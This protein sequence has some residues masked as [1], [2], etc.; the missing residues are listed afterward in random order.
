MD[1]SKPESVSVIVVATDFSPGSDLAIE[2]AALLARQSDAELWL[3]HVFDDGLWATIKNIYD[4]ERWAATEPILAA[5]DRLSRLSSEVAERYAIRVHGETRTGRV[6]T[7]IVAFADA[8]SAKLLVV[9]EHGED[10]ISD[11]VLGGTTLK[12]LEQTKI[13]LLMVCRRPANEA[14][15][16]GSRGVDYSN[17]LVAVDFSEEARRAAQQAILLFPEAKFSL[18]HAYFVPFEGRMRL[19]GASN[20]DIE[21]YRTA[22][23]LR[24][25]QKM[26][27]FI[28]QLAAPSE[29]RSSEYF[30]RGSPAAAILEQ[31]ERIGADLI[32]IGKHGGS[33]VEERLLGSVTRNV[34]Y[35]AGC[36]VL[37]VP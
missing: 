19:A 34:L 4:A 35:H 18:V 33:I 7:E 6:A 20:A 12:V 32:V 15:L 27:G 30:V 9:G 36:D 23:C 24:V 10:W 28:E 21:R 26:R 17:L 1:S 13:P 37:L 31:G 22:E 11:T 2:R 29:L 5:R 14:D 3:L 16:E 25:E 8:Q